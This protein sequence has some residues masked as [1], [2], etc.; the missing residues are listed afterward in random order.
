MNIL[1]LTLPLL[2]M[3]LLIGPCSGA[4]Q[5]SISSH[6]QHVTAQDTQ[7]QLDRILRHQSAEWLLMAPHLPDTQTGSAEQLTMA[8]DVLRARRMTEDALDY[9]NYALLR[10]GDEAALRNRVGVTEMELRHPELAR[11][12]FNRVLKI[13][14]KN[15][16][17]WNNLGATDY[18]A[19][20]YRGA[21]DRYKH[22]LKL[23]RNSAVYHSN[24]GTAYFELADYD[25]ARHEFAVAIKLDPAIFDQGGWAGL[26]AHVLSPHDRGRFCVEMARLAALNHD[27]AGVLHWLNMAVSTDSESASSMLRDAAFNSYRKDPRV[28]LVLQNARTLRG[29]QMVAS[30][31]IPPLPSAGNAEDAHR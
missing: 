27:D 3:P 4:S 13:D 22:A 30:G 26:Q 29:H 12:S 14:R 21:V 8:G 1:R 15:A 24:L 28:L 23:N 17:A 11:I 9:Y 19:G 7:Q 10:G 20:D 6:R 31:P 16:P 2:V 25:S 5:N 18:L